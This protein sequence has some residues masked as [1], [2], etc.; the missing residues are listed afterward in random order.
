MS[1]IITSKANTF[2]GEDCIT[3]IHRGDFKFYGAKLAD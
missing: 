2:K 3:E 1:K